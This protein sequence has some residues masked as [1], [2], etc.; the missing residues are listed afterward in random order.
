MTFIC[1]A[2]SGG[3][4]GGLAD[5]FLGPIGVAPA[6]FG[7]AADQRNRVVG[8]LRRHGILQ[9]RLPRIVLFV[10][11]VLV[12]GAAWQP[13]QRAADLH[14]RR[15]AQIGA[16]SHSRDV[17]CK[18]NVGARA[19][20]MG[21]GWSDVANDGNGGSEHVGDHLAHAG[22]KAARRVQ[23]QDNDVDPPF[24]RRRQRFL[25]VPGGCRTDCPVDLDHQRG[26]ADLLRRQG[27]GRG[28]LD[29]GSNRR[30]KGRLHHPHGTT[31][32]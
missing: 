8:R 4:T 28:K 11:A 6:Q 15:G 16:W 25:H 1:K 27:R 26:F 3:K 12:R 5:G 24:A 19:R 23:T 13:R 17:R 32:Q 21:T 14:G 2:A 7:E 29:S 30:N 18:K 31:P 22:G 9:R 20:R 10:L